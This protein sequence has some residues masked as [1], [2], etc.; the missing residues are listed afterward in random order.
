MDSL[1]LFSKNESQMIDDVRI[2]IT[3]LKWDGFENDS[4][5]IKS[6]TLGLV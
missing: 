1:F 4:E 6:N 5:T 2:Y 3:S